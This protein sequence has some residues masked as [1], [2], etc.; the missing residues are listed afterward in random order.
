M[1]RECPSA[2][3]TEYFTADAEAAGIARPGHALEEG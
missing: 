2:C 3:E 1:R